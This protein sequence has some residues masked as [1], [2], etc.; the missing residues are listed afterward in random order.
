M[1]LG[2]FAKTFPGTQP[3]PV[4]AAAR[5]AGFAGV[6]YNMACSGLAAMPDTIDD[7]TIAG[8]ADAAVS[9]GVTIEALSATYNMIHPDHAIRRQGI[10]RLDLLLQTAARLQIP[11]VTLCTGTRDP[12]DQWRHHE[13]N[14]TPAAWSDLVD[15]MTKAV[16]LAERHGV[17]LGIEP[18]QANVV[19]SATDA[20]RLIG[21]IGSRRIRIVLDP[22]NL[23]E[24][25]TPA[26]V[27]RIVAEAV[28]MLA[29]HIAMAHAKD[30]HADGRFATVG[31]GIVVFEDFLSR[32][33]S[34]GFEGPLVTHGLEASEA[35]GVARY[36]AGLL[37]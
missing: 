19:T 21:E 11:L 35:E 31:Q 17:D 7:A 29:G 8:I 13:D 30:R 12:I 26:E 34:V 16:A 33:S 22:A 1:R 10:K 20:L 6:Q 2:I 4:L 24:T 37:P 14:A 18:E 25:G 27:R 36:L 15:E 32:L 23:F 3:L 5:G 9:T 28:D